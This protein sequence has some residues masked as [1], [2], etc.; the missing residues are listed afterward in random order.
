MSR[1][2]L[3]QNFRGFDIRGVPYV[4][5]NREIQ[6]MPVLS[7]LITYRICGNTAPAFYLFL[8]AFSIVQYLNFSLYCLEKAP[9]W[10][11]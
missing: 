11:K 4:H 7:L 2:W 6:G 9:F 10:E 5:I 1:G 8:R 3:C